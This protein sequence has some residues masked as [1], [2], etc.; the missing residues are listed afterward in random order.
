[1]ST[2]SGT[3][4]QGAENRQQGVVHAKRVSLPSQ[5]GILVNSAGSGAQPQPQKHFYEFFSFENASDS[6]GTV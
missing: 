2:A 1:M 6:S 3:V 4:G 5:L